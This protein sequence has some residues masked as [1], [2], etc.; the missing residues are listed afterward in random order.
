MDRSPTGKRYVIA[1]DITLAN[2][3]RLTTALGVG[4]VGRSGDPQRGR[5]PAE[6]AAPSRDPRRRGRQGAAAQD[7]GGSG[8]H[9]HA[10]ALPVWEAAGRPAS[11]PLQFTGQGEL[12]YAHFDTV[13]VG[14]TR[15]VV[16]AVAPRSDFVL[17][18]PWH[19]AA[20][21]A[22]FLAAWRWRC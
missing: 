18:R 22:I 7:S 11:T 20:A 21:A 2:L 16:A 13:P 8:L 19:L 10:A 1:F 6:H 5:T 4:E 14:A 15:F 9:V 12:W 3:S 17:G